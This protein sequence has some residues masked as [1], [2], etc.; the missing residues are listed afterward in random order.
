MRRMQTNHLS[1]P[2]PNRLFMRQMA[3]E[4]TAFDQSSLGDVT[5]LIIDRDGKY[6]EDFLRL[7]SDEGIEAVNRLEGSG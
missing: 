6:A 1:T 4:M 7:L 3:V 2:S 5:H